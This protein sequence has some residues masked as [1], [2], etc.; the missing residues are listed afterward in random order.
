MP[1][2]WSATSS[3]PSVSRTV[4]VPSGGLHLAA[5]SS[6]LVTARSRAAASPVTH[7]GSACRSKLQAA[8]PP[9]Y[10][11]HGPLDDL[12]EV[13]LPPAR[14]GPGSLAGQLGEVA[15]QRGELLDLELHVVEQLGP[16]LG[17]TARPGRSAWVSRSRLV[18]SEVSGVRSSWPASATSWR[19]RSRE[20]DSAASIALNARASRAISSLPSTVDRVELLGA[21]DV[22]GGVR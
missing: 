11:L 5:L 6:R 15:D 14:P 20:A 4:T 13:D 1:W 17:R 21:G 22:L 9:A 8:G 19:C 18:R 3:T 2:P 7:H 16:G 12:R 10:P